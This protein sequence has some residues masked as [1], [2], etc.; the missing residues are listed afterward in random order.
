MRLLRLKAGF[1]R[2]VSATDISLHPQFNCIYGHN[3]SGKSTLLE[4]IYCLGRGRSFRTHLTQPIVQYRAEACHVFAELASN[5]ITTTIGFEKSIRSKLRLKMGVNQQAPTLIELA[6][7][8]PI[9]LIHPNCH[10]L[11]NHGPKRRRQFLNWG[12][13]H[14]E[15]QFLPLWQQLSHALKQRNAALQQSQAVSCVTAWDYEIVRVGLLLSELRQRYFELLKGMVS[16]FLAQLLDFYSLEMAY[17]PGWDAKQDLSTCFK[18]NLAGDIS[19][20]YTRMGPHRFDLIL[21]IH[22]LPVEL[23]LSRGEQKRLICALYLAQG[24]LIQKLSGKHCIYLLD[25]VMHEL[26]THY[27]RQLWETLEQLECQVFITAIS[28]SSFDRFHTLQNNQQFHI[29]QGNI[30]PVS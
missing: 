6:D 19:R 27:Q 24:K 17:Y 2:N 23:V 9:Q 21:K 15:P 30:V 28:S 8:L 10:D 26:D 22:D 1:F 25:D 3:G 7:L 29:D 11:L 13:F 20:R 18:Q 16:H 12:M 4:M 5:T 14:V